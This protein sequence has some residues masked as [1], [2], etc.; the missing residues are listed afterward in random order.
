MEVSKA[1]VK[2]S[3]LIAKEIAVAT[4]PYFEGHCAK[5]CLVKVAEIVHPEKRQSC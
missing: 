2:A 1:V 3:Y 5:N 4:K